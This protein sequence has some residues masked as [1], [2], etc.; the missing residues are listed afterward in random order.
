VELTALW[1]QRDPRPSSWIWGV[2]GKMS[3]NLER[4][5]EGKETE[6]GGKRKEKGGKGERRSL[7]HWL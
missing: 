6:R 1:G 5:R 3:G 4:A 7:R 2:I